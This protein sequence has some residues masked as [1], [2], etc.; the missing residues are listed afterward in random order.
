MAAE[1][2]VADQDGQAGPRSAY[3]PVSK[4]ASSFPVGMAAIRS[5]ARGMSWRYLLGTGGHPSPA[6]LQASIEAARASSEL[7]MPLTKTSRSG[8]R[9]RSATA[10]MLNWSA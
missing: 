7:P 9:S 5:Q 8:Q 6:A 10:V 2:A 4:R 1:H 3:S